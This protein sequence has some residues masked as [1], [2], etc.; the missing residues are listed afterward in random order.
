MRIV[1]PEP[2]IENWCEKLKTGDNTYMTLHN[3]NVIY[4]D[5]MYLVKSL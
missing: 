1:S 2:E 3:I 4:K 5:C